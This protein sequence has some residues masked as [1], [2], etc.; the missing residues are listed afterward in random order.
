MISGPDAI[1]AELEVIAPVTAVLGNTDSSSLFPLTQTATLGGRKFLVH[2]IVDPQ[3]LREELRLR[4]EHER[5]DMVVFGH[6]HRLYW[7]TVNGVQY[8]NPGY[9]GK[10][11][12]GTERSIA[13][14]HLTG[15]EI[16]PEFPPL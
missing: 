13:I 3:A 9:A 2:H 7:G 16:R 10:P 11:K 12:G 14:L 15:N 5:P 1:I 8:L 6:T 4:I